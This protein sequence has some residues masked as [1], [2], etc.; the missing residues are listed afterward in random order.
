MARLTRAETKA[1][2]RVRLLESAA[3]VF[4]ERGFHAATVEE[5]SE[6]AG[7]SKGAFYAHFADKGA[8]LMTILEDYWA[9]QMAE[10]DELVANAPDEEKLTV[11]Q[12]WFDRLVMDRS[13]D[14]AI[15][16]FTPSA[17]RNPELRRRFIQ[18][19]AQIRAAIS[20][21]MQAYCA[22]ADID[23]PIPA[24]HFA[25]LVL[26]LGS[27]LENQRHLDPTALPSDLFS[28]A[29]F[30]LWQGLFPEEAQ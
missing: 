7:Y 21:M 1:Q 3:R 30:Y 5:I 6:A 8:C 24:E 28:Q 16:E 12:Q 14:L 9:H 13:L 27:G 11:T 22:G 17:L 10:V 19:D 15:T 20:T 23:L 25:A 2:T 26:A 4:E 29:L 18:R